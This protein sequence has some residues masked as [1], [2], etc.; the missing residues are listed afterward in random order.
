MAINS[1]APHRDLGTEDLRYKSALATG[2]RPRP[3]SGPWA[4]DAG[5][6]ARTLQERH[7]GR[8]TAMLTYKSAHFYRE[9]HA[10]YSSGL[11]ILWWRLRH[12]CHILWLAPLMN[13]S[14][15]HLYYDI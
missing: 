5:L 3:A 11:N 9:T 6:V 14:E 2:L 1:F 7:A 12:Q 8:L 15:F 13:N 4:W 10:P